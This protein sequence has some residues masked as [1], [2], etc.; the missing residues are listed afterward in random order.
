MAYRVGSVNL[1]CFIFWGLKPGQRFLIVLKT[2]RC[3]IESYKMKIKEDGSLFENN[4]RKA[5]NAFT[6]RVRMTRKTKVRRIKG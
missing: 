5:E 4:G 1:R 6:K 3:Y 2:N